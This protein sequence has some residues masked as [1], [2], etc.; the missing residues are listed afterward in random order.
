MKPNNEKLSAAKIAAIRADIRRRAE[1]EK[2]AEEMRQY[3]HQ[4]IAA[5]HGVSVGSIKKYGEKETSTQEQQ[6]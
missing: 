4:A 1:L 2:L 5:R 3:T 6:Q